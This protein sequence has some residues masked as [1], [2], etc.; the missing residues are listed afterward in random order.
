MT[1]SPVPK[2]ESEEWVWHVGLYAE[3]SDILND[4]YLGKEVSEERQL[5]L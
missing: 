4:V 5:R 2:I 3:A 1:V